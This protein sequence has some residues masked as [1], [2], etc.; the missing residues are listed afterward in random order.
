[1]SNINEL[2]ADATQEAFALQGTIEALAA[3][4]DALRAA[5]ESI[6]SASTGTFHYGS[7]ASAELAAIARAALA[8]KWG[9]S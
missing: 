5:L 1:M 9:A 4:R 2:L 7:K 3:E 8:G 6:V